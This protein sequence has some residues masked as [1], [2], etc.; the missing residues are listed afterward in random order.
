[1]Q[2][3]SIPPVHVGHNIQRFRLIRGYSQAGLAH[4][5]EVKRNKAVSQQLISDIE[6]RETIADEELL[7][8]IAEILEVSP[9]ALKALDIDSAINVISNTFN[10]NSSPIIQHQPIHSTVNQTFNPLDKLIE[11]FEKE[12]GELR[13]ENERLK[14][15]NDALKI[16]NQSLNNGKR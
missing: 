16:E 5:L 7:K 4:E 15:E 6:D 8:Q 3:I 12:K 1:M 13:K 2:N 14:T 11:L 10:D 9:E